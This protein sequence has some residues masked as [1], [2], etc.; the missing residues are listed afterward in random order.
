LFLKLLVGP[1]CA[2]RLLACN[3]ALI[4]T[5]RTPNSRSVDNHVTPHQILC[6]NFNLLFYSNGIT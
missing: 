1:L 4:G 3:E 6:F 5:T 2:N